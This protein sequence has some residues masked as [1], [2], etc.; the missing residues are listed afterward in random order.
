MSHVMFFTRAL[1]WSGALMLSAGLLM[2]VAPLAETRLL[3]VV[4]DAVAYDW[5]QESEG[6]WSAEIHMIKYRSCSPTET[7]GM[8]YMGP[9]RTEGKAATVL[10]P[11][12]P[13]PYEVPI[14]YLDDD[15][16]GSS[17]PAIEG[18]QSFGR[19]QFGSPGR[20]VYAGSTMIMEPRHN[21]HGIYD[22]VSRVGPVV[23]GQ[24]S[25]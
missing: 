10:N 5:R 13:P 24:D 7:W 2:S 21:C 22:T 6:R 23:V 19:W 20:P 14:R 15:T 25:D 17:H 4:G 12:E 11:L 9:S 8:N 3:P 16:P 18:R 1:L